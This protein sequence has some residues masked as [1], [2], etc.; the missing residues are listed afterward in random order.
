MNFNNEKIELKKRIDEDVRTLYTDERK[1]NKFHLNEKLFFITNSLWDHFQSILEPIRQ[2]IQKLESAILVNRYKLDET[3]KKHCKSKVDFKRA[4]SELHKVEENLDSH[5][6]EMQ[7]IEDHFNG[8]DAIGDLKRLPMKWFFILM[9]FVAAAEIV[10]YF[11][12]FLSQE[13]GLI[14]ELDSDWEKIKYYIF[15][16]V[17]A[18]GFTIMLIWLAHK[19][20][21]ML[22]Q[23]VSIHPKAIKAYW[24]KFIVIALIVLS[25]IFA[26]V[27]MRGQMHHILGLETKIEKG[28]DDPGND[29]RFGSHKN[30][31]LE[32]SNKSENFEKE[33]IDT[34]QKLSQLFIIINLFIVIAGMFLAYEVHTSSVKYEALEGMIKRLDAR[35]K[36]LL[37]EKKKLEVA[38]SDNEKDELLATLQ[39]YV[40]SVNKFDEYSQKVKSYKISI[41]NI[42]IEMIYYMFGSMVEH[43]LLTE[44]EENDLDKYSP[45]YLSERFTKEWKLETIDIT[46]DEVMHINNIDKFVESFK[47]KEEKNE[48]LT[49]VDDVN[50]KEEKENEDV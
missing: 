22:R 37:K 3:L 5:R 29:D 49:L 23:Y 46:T 39:E 35:R 48:I 24:I 31:N 18:T 13:I 25:A 47:C 4:E 6:K 17:M 1:L 41:E 28:M 14:S 16:G 7:K 45:E 21:M 33:I 32:N 36:K 30:K 34:K 43:K 8:E 38:L 26:T 10:V 2:Q 12:V 50:K 11:N 40:D 15:A 19:L 27:K 44:F 20:G 9:F 42:Y